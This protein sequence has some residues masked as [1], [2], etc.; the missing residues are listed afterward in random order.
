MMFYYQGKEID[1]D[2]MTEQVKRILQGRD[3]DP[4]Y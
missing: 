1:D 3:I 4:A 2:Q